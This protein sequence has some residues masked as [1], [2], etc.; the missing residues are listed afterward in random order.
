M[1]EQLREPIISGGLRWELMP[2]TIPI[3][4]KFAPAQWHKIHAETDTDEQFTAWLQRYESICTPLLLW[5]NGVHIAFVFVV[6][7]NYMRK[8]VMIH[9]GTW[10]DDRRY[11]IPLFRAT[12]TLAEHLLGQGFKV[13]S[14]CA[15]DNTVSKRFLRACGFVPYAR[16]E[17]YIKL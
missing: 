9:G 10:F 1:I 13:H 8:S 11:S 3:V 4:G 7:D 2:P 5:R 6:Y 14:Q 17:G 12:I 15:A 16:R